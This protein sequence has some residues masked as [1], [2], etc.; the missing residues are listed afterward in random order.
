[1]TDYLK[2]PIIGTLTTLPLSTIFFNTTEKPKKMHLTNKGMITVFDWG[3]APTI[4][5]F[6]IKLDPTECVQPQAPDSTVCSAN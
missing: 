4:L 6:K 2:G 5:Y 3:Y 1:M